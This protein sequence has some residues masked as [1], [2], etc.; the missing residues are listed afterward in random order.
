[1]ISDAHDEASRFVFT[2]YAASSRYS[3]TEKANNNPQRLYLLKEDFLPMMMDLILVQFAFPNHYAK[4]IC[5][6][7]TLFRLILAF[8]FSKKRPNFIANTVKW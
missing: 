5:S 2:L 3:A 4:S 1:M 6:Y 7:V 8:I